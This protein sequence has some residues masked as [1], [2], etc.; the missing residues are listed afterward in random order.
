MVALKKI[1]FCLF[2]LFF[3]TQEV[4]SA[5]GVIIVLEAPLYEKEMKGSAIVEYIR[6]GER[7]FIH[8][9]HLDLSP[10]ERD[11]GQTIPNIQSDFYLVQDKNGQ[12]AY[13]EK[14]FVKKIYKDERENL[15]P[16][17]PFDHDPT[18]Y[19]LK[20]P[21][22]PKYPALTDDRYRAFIN[23][24][25]GP[26]TKVNYPYAD[27]LKGENYNLRRGVELAYLKNI[28]F[29]IVN[30]FY[31]GAK[32]HFWQDEATFT[33][34]DWNNEKKLATEEHGQFGVGSYVSY[35][36][37]RDFRYRVSFNGGFTFNWNRTYVNLKSKD[38]EENRFFS[39]YTI[40]PSLGTLLQFP[41]AL[42]R[43][44][45]ILGSSLQFNLPYELLPAAR[46]INQT[47]WNK[48]SDQIAY[49]FGGVFTVFIGLQTSY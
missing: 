41:N 46:P 25:T 27:T 5:E 34:Y 28:E 9:R 33:L 2:L 1:S 32:F 18:D 47:S 37:Y 49:P 3:F 35:D 13:I 36:A 29:D 17:S 23:L 42:P 26:A 7:I 45:I 30:R 8:D 14:R 16:I 38:E 48:D 15:E 10:N 24:A 19:R 43:A 20:E 40:T 6:K 22:P 12:D 21:L 11:Y 31:F 39:A 4:L 44:D